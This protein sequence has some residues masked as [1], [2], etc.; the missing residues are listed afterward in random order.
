[1]YLY[2]IVIWVKCYPRLHIII[3]QPPYIVTSGTAYQPSTTF[4]SLEV[5]AEQSSSLGWASSTVLGFMRVYVVFQRYVFTMIPKH[6]SGLSSAMRRLHK[7]TLIM[8]LV[9][10]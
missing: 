9:C 4:C 2:I 3:K 8:F 7:D 5:Q 10:G 6:T 1:M